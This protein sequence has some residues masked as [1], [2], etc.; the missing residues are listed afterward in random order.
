[1]SIWFR[2]VDETKYRFLATSGCLFSRKLWWAIGVGSFWPK[3]EVFYRPHE[4]EFW[5]FSNSKMNVTDRS[6]KVDKK[7][8]SFV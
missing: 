6:K 7:I 5:L 4:I 3:I 2:R 1:M 8:G